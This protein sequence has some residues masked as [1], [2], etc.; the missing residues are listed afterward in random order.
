MQPIDIK[1]ITIS[2]LI[3]AVFS[4]ISVSIF[5]HFSANAGS[6]Q[7]AL[8]IEGSDPASME[9]VID[10][11]N[12]ADAFASAKAYTAAD[13]VVPNSYPTKLNITDSFVRHLA[14]QMAEENP[15][16]PS[17]GD[18]GSP[19]LIVP[20]DLQAASENFV[21]S[22]PAQ[23]TPSVI[24]EKDVNVQNNPTQQDISAYSENLVS[25]LTQTFSKE[26]INS[27][28]RRVDAS[29]NK[30]DAISLVELS[31]RQ[32][33]VKLEKLPTPKQLVPLQIAALT[34]YSNQATLY[35]DMAAYESD[36]MKAYVATNFA[37]Q[38]TGKDFARLQAE[39]AK[40][41]KLAFA[42]HENFALRDA[43]AY[44]A[45]L[46]QTAHAIPGFVSFVFD[47]PNTANTWA[48]FAKELWKIAR[49]AL[50]EIIKDKLIHR[51]VAETVKWIQG[52]GSPQF[53]TNWEGFL[54]NVGD[55]AAGLMI[56]KIAPNLCST[57]RPFVKVQL[58]QIA[59]GPDNLTPNCTIDKVVSNLESF[60]QDFRTGGWLQFQNSFQPENNPYGALTLGIQSTLN[61]QSKERNAKNSEN[62]AAKGFLGKKECT[63]YAP[64]KK[65]YEYISCTAPGAQPNPD[66]NKDSPCVIEKT[67]K[68]ACETSVTR[69]PGETLGASLNNA[70]GAP[71]QRIVNAQDITALTSALFNA[72][73]MKLMTAAKG[74]LMALTSTDSKGNA[75][76]DGGASMPAVAGGIEGNQ[77]CQGITDPDELA[78]CQKGMGIVDGSV[79]KTPAS[80]TD[81]QTALTNLKSYLDS[82]S[83]TI[84]ADTKWLAQKEDILASLSAYIA[85]CPAEQT[86]AS[87][88]Q[89]SITALTSGVQKEIS[90]MQ[91]AISQINAIILQV[92]AAKDTQE[93]ATIT[94]SISQYASLGTKN[95]EAQT[96]LTNLDTI[97]QQIT[98]G[99]EQDPVTGAYACTPITATP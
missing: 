87:K 64:D 89:S 18:D 85:A 32:G 92:N 13:D 90:D 57:F 58:Q 80:D 39:A 24:T 54:K 28:Q 22:L 70:M 30:L 4:G 27:L 59:L 78:S 20:D 83:S 94:D 96:R 67:I 75:V 53:V 98:A 45:F 1:K 99:L 35:A 48:S 82:A 14:R 42:E 29:E 71:I 88:V 68:G 49:Q 93:L 50:T 6:S 33:L 61:K 84:D 16:G 52:G 34:L 11:A 7:N 43:V 9:A 17:I 72:A 46:P 26:T 65:V 3:L 79:V 47:I 95:T 25:V 2:F 81:K 77:V 91:T 36:P 12:S 31:F 69:T 44:I 74:S 41:G 21:L 56:D 23:F 19:Q 10:S 97:Q 51:L 73:F 15:D 66:G 62:I 37:E 86:T 8:K 60:Y 55:E 40:A 63:K 5:A 76:Y 38:S